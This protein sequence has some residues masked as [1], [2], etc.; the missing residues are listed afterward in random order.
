MNTEN[1][2]CKLSD[3]ELRLRGKKL[4]TLWA[5]IAQIETRKKVAM[6]E[7]KQE[8][9]SR[10]ADCL[11]LVKQINEGQEW[12]EVQIEEVKDWEASSVRTIRIDTGEM[13]NVRAMTPR[14]TQRHLEFPTLAPVEVEMTEQIN[15]PQEAVG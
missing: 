9:E 1:L 14:E 3:E 10:E 13:V 5:E 6:Q 2:P 12:R 11:T 15:K 8:I 7:F 4:A